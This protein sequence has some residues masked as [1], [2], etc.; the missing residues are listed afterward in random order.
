MVGVCEERLV[1][2]VLA[3]QAEFPEVIGDVFANVSDRA[4]GANDDLRVFVRAL[5]AVLVLDWL[6]CG[7]GARHHPAAC[8]LA[9]VFEIEHAGLLE[10]LE[11]SVP[12]FEVKDFALAGQEIVFN[13]QAQHGFKM[14]AQ[15]G[16]R[17]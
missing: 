1:A 9:F 13:V 2:E 12:E 6:C 4:V 10:L 11:G 17:N 14:A 8:V 7:S 16:G 5:R 15:D 3:E